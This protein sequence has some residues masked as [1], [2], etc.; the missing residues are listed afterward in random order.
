MRAPPFRR[1]VKDAIDAARNAGVA[2]VE[3]TTADGAA[4]KFKFNGEAEAPTDE[5]DDV[6]RARIRRWKQSK[7]EAQSESKVR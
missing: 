5:S 6:L 2:S 4:Y 3:I 7:H 1:R